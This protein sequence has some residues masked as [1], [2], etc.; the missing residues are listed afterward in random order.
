MHLLFP[1][2]LAYR[3]VGKRGYADFQPKKDTVKKFCEEQE[4]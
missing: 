3:I 4:S 2:N 1:L